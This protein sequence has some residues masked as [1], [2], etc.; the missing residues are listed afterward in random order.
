MPF[1]YREDYDRITIH[2]CPRNPINQDSGTTLR[3]PHCHGEDHNHITSHLCSH[4][5][6][7]RNRAIVSGAI[8]VAI[9]LATPKATS[10][11]AQMVRLNRRQVNRSSHDV[12]LIE[13]HPCHDQII[14]FSSSESTTV[15]RQFAAADSVGSTPTSVTPGLVDQVLEVGRNKNIPRIF[16]IIAFEKQETVRYMDLRKMET[17]CVH[18]NAQHWIEVLFL[19]IC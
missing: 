9:P 13:N 17:S 6:K 4:N 1:C 14:T 10:Q 19:L 18:C 11:E 3:C 5:L 7:N 2:L 12:E 15:E 16:C 8:S